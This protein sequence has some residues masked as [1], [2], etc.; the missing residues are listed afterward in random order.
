MTMAERLLWLA[1]EMNSMALRGRPS[2][3]RRAVST[4]YY[5][6]FHAIAG[7]C[8][9][10]ILPEKEGLDDTREFERVYRALEHG[11]L[12]REFTQT[13][14]K[15]NEYLNKIGAL[16]V[17]LQSERHKADYLPPKR[18]YSFDEASKLIESAGLAMELL[19]KL[20]AG[21]RRILAITLLFK[22]RPQ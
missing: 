21:N 20:D 3:Q 14:L 16:V 11:S 6:V 7:L 12:K 19:E 1:K 9:E 15:D 10:G 17:R 2:V 8:A 22:N 18:L 5:A 4:A 13:P